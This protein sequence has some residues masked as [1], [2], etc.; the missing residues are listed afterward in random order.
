[1]VLYLGVY[2]F[3]Q[4]K[5]QCNEMFFQRI[6][7]DSDTTRMEVVFVKNGRDQYRKTDLINRKKK[8]K[9]WSTAQDS[10]KRKM[11]QFKLPS[12]QAVSAHQKICKLDMKGH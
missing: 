12:Y 2:R 7:T 6:Y 3:L 5:G 10:T 9:T 1:M 8:R 4:M 11:L